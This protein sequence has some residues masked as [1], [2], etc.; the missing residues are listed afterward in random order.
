[1]REK[2]NH[3]LEYENEKKSQQIDN[4]LFILLILIISFAA[5]YQYNRRKRETLK[6][7][8]RKAQQLKE[9]SYKRSLAYIEENKKRIVELEQELSQASFTNSALQKQLKEQKELIFLE[10][11]QAEIKQAK[12]QEAKERIKETSIYRT[13]NRR[14]QDPMGRVF[15]TSEEWELIEEVIQHEHPSFIEK[16]KEI[17]PFNPYEQ[18][19]CLLIKMNFSPSAISKLLQRPKETITSTRR[20][21]FKRIF[22]EQGKPEEWDSFIHS[23]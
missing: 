17:H 4:T 1:V 11:R 7:Q 6:A 23:L 18:Q 10:T 16:L 15:I 5:Y 12:H 3:R 2:E 13:L 20:R 21:L 22:K 8:H 19:L 14:L 9:E